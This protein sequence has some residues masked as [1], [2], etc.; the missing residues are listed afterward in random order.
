MPEQRKT[1]S[2]DVNM[3][4]LRRLRQCEELPRMGAARHQVVARALGRGAGKDGRLDVQEALAVEKIAHRRS[5]ARAQH[6]PLLHLGAPQVHV[7]VLQA[8]VLA[9]VGVL[10]E[11]GRGGGAIATAEG[12]F[13]FVV[14]TDVQAGDIV[15]AARGADKALISEVSV[16]D[17]FV[18]PSLGE[19][20]KSIAIDV[21]LQP[22]DKTLTDEEID[23]VA[24]AIVAAVTK[25]TGG[26]LR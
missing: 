11:L 18:G 10:G 7:A 24:Q 17:V 15:R 22:R 19:G 16:F 4:E 25:K 26:T 5:D 3:Q 23:S 20:R 1:A 12:D 6:Q 13:A 21:T 2:E 9:D 14:D 8:H